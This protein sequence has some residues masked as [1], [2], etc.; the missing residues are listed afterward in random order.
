MLLTLTTPWTKLLAALRAL[1]VPRHVHPRARHGLPLHLPPAELGDRH[2]H[3]PQGAHRSATTD[4]DASGRAFVAATAGALFGKAHALS[5]EVHLAMVSRGYT[6]DARRSRPRSA[7]GAIDV[8]R[9]VVSPPVVA[10]VIAAS[11]RASTVP[12]ER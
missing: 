4:D 12:A 3:G 9:A 10:A 5:E 7:C 6:G 1:F 8:V 11:T 2:V